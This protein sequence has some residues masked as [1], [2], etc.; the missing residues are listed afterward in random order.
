MVAMVSSAF[1]VEPK[2]ELRKGE[3][4]TYIGNN[5][6][7]RMQHESWLE[8]YIQALYPEYDLSFRN[9]GYPGD[10]LKVRNREDNFGSPDQ[11]LAKTQADVIFAFFGYNEALKGEGRSMVSAKIW[12]RRSMACS[13]KTI[14]ANR[15]RG[16][17]S[18]RRL[19]TRI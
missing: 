8:T 16:S 9:L 14:T 18:S 13:R 11:W 2:L 6:A 5:L 1:A 10:E 17:S 19:L 4:I 15:R 12:N 3:H 7:D